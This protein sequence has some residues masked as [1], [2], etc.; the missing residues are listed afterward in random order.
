MKSYKCV[1]SRGKASYED[2]GGDLIS[3]AG[4]FPVQ[5]VLGAAMHNNIHV[6]IF[7]VSCILLLL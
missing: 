6:L 5:E 4:S 3:R 1:Y 7:L 2:V